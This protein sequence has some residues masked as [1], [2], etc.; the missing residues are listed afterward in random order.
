MKEDSLSEEKKTE[1]HGDGELFTGVFLKH[2]CLIALRSIQGQTLSMFI[3]IE[4][5]W[6]E[7][8]YYYL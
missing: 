8:V 3:I 5:A 6:R 7:G 2:I 4:T 1:M